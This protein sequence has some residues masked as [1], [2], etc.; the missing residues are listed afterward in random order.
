MSP[1]KNE[2]IKIGMLV[3]YEHKDFRLDDGYEDIEIGLIVSI[4]EAHSAYG[5]GDSYNVEWFYPSRLVP[6]G[7]FRYYK[8][9]IVR[10][11]LKYLKYRED[12]CQTTMKITQK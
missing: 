12:V 5:Y 4:D 7:I 1:A 8:D 6:S 9:A 10:W 3:M 2:E 11:R